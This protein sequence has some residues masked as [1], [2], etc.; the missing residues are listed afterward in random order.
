MKTVCPLVYIVVA[1]AFWLTA[2]TPEGTPL[3]G[4]VRD[5]GAVEMPDLAPPKARQ[6]RT[7]LTRNAR[8]IWGLDAPIPLFGAQIEVESAW[9]ETA[10]S[11]AGAKGL[12]QFIPSTADWIDDAY[13]DLGKAEPF[14]PD[15]ALRALVRYDFHLY[16]RVP[17]SRSDCDRYGFTLAAYNGG[18]KWVARDR[19]LATQKGRDANQYWGSVE[20]VNAGRTEQAWGENRSYPIMI[21]KQRQP[22]YALWGPL[23][24][25]EMIG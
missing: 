6:Y 23:V 13:P 7:I 19:Q 10:V 9:N 3:K 20:F 11:S 15:W 24:C 4:L 5:V 2:C 14:N 25:R 1:C 18:E 12:A 8:V 16:G 22:S 17:S 21:I